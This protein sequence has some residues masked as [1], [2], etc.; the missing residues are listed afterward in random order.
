ML[1]GIKNELTE[2]DWIH[3]G[4]KLHRIAETINNINKMQCSRRAFADKE[5]RVPKV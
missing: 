5:E 2:Y 1:K 3:V 4:Y